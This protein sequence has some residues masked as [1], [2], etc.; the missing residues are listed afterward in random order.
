MPHTESWRSLDQHEYTHV[1]LL[2]A[3]VSGILIQMLNTPVL[4]GHLAQEAIAD[5]VDLSR[6][7]HEAAATFG[8]R[9]VILSEFGEEAAMRFTSDLLA[10]PAT[11]QAY[12]DPF[13]VMCAAI[14]RI[15]SAGLLPMLPKGK[16]PKAFLAVVLAEI[17]LNAPLFDRL[18][19][20]TKGTKSLSQVLAIFN[21]RER[22]CRIEGIACDIFEAVFPRSMT[23]DEVAA[24]QHDPLALPD[25]STG[26]EPYKR[27]SK[28]IDI[29]YD[30]YNHDPLRTNAMVRR[31]RSQALA[32]YVEYA[33]LED[34]LIARFNPAT[35]ELR[36]AMEW[37]RGMQR[38]P[39]H[40]VSSAISFPRWSPHGGF[41]LLNPS[42]ALLESLR[43]LVVHTYIG[44]ASHDNSP[45]AV[46]HVAERGHGGVFR[47]EGP[48]VIE[49]IGQLRGPQEHWFVV[50]WRAYDFINKRISLIDCEIP[51]LFMVCAATDGAILAKLAS[52]LAR[53]SYRKVLILSESLNA[54]FPVAIVKPEADDLYMLIIMLTR[55]QLQSFL[56]AIEPD[57]ANWVVDAKG[58]HKLSGTRIG[59]LNCVVA[60]FYALGF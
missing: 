36:D 32:H 28:L 41:P 26:E 27:L 13:F 10:N 35:S 30:T 29:D 59:Q 60:H 47:T 56:F 11:K 12:F 52:V 1:F 44:I 6:F 22:L 51:G 53:S 43:E 20:A 40:A 18:A 46:V 14:Y 4:L 57:A 48:K 9:E 39:E 25:Y 15:E 2:R 49:C 7:A 37:A 58:E 23:A 3:T 5:L 19:H 17:A 16:A 21:S 34:L 50:D 31:H 42:R 55:S 54:S 38:R 45:Y 8:Q 33:E 24:L